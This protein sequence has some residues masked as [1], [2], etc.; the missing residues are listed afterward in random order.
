MLSN[1]IQPAWAVMEYG[2]Y[3]ALALIATPY[4]M[5]TLGPEKYGHWMLLTATVGF[6]GILSAGTGAAVIKA[7]SAGFGRAKAEDV[8]RAIRSSLVIAFV[9]GG[10][11]T[12]FI[13]A[14][15]LV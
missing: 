4:F 7:V 2:W 3:P 6:G 14:V 1:L 10:V 12:G 11:M 5:H 9:S 13:L 8:E 15:F